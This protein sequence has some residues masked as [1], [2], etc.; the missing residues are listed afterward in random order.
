MTV[1]LQG[2]QLVHQDYIHKMPLVLHDNLQ[3]ESHKPY[4]P[5]TTVT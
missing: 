3:H 5:P 2:H 4:G 1:L